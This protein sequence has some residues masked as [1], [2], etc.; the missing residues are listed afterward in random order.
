MPFGW[1][2]VYVWPFGE[3][4]CGNQE[5]WVPF[6]TLQEGSCYVNGSHFKHC[7]D[8]LMVDQAQASGL[9]TLADCTGVA[10]L[11]PSLSVTS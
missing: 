1:D 11:A 6:L 4:V 7:C 5:V 8:V 10:L 3:V 9:G 2:S